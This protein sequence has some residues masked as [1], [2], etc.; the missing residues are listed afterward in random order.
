MHP[1]L[2]HP[3]Q[4]SYRDSATALKILFYCLMTGLSA[5]TPLKET[6]LTP[7]VATWFL[8]G[9]YDWNFYCGLSTIGQAPSFTP[10]RGGVLVGFENYFDQ[11]S[12]LFP[13]QASHDI[14]YR[15]A[16]LFDLGGLPNVVAATLTF[17]FEW[18]SMSGPGT[19]ADSAAR[20]LWLRTGDSV[21]YQADPLLDL[22]PGD[23]SF[24]IDVST[25][26]R[27]WVNGTTENRGFVISGPNE[28]FPENNDTWVSSYT[29]FRLHVV[30]NPM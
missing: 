19:S 1:L 6:T 10:D 2:W 13:C 12:G 4:R 21:F 11:G 22:S 16:V 27:N 7:S 26:V 17:G 20:R 24:S 3:V 8:R 5:C 28:L 15:G 23:H 14:V 18:T 29:N 9:G 30:Y 25:V